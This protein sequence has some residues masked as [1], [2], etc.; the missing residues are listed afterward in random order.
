[1]KRHVTVDGVRIRVDN[2]PCCCSTDAKSGER[3]AK[4]KAEYVT[5]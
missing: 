1:M 2:L 3:S 4:A 5:R